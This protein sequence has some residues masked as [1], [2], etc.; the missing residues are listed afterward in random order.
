M[1]KKVC[2]ISLLLLI[3]LVLGACDIITGNVDTAYTDDDIDPDTG[4]SLEEDII[5]GDDGLTYVNSCFSSERGVGVDHLGACEYEVCQVGGQD[6][7][8]LDNIVYYEDDRERPYIEVLYGTFYINENGGW[9]YI[10]AINTESSYY[11]NRMSEYLAGVSEKGVEITCETTD[12][13]PDGLKEYLITHG[14]MLD[15][16][17]EGWTDDETIAAS[18]VTA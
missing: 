11:A 15:L 12:D 14:K 17:I 6:H 10:K 9:T 7:Y 3:L 1:Q 18:E 4:C 16:K 8:F 13:I 2:I 5:C